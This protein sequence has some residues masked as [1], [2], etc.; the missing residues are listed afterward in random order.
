MPV[1]DTRHSTEPVSHARVCFFDRMQD[2]R[3]V[4]E[5]VWI[6]EYDYRPDIRCEVIIGE[7]WEP[8]LI[9]VAV[10]HKVDED[11]AGKIKASGYC[12]IEIDLASLLKQKE[13]SAGDL[14]QALTEPARIT[15]VNK[16]SQLMKHLKAIT[17]QE[18]TAS[19]EAC[20]LEIRQWHK[21]ISKLLLS[22]QRI[23]LPRY[24]Y[25]EE[26]LANTIKLKDGKRYP[27][28]K[29]EPPTIGGVLELHDV[30]A[31]VDSRFD[32]QL[33]YNGKRY[34]LPVVLNI[35][36][37]P[38]ENLS[39]SYLVLN[40]VSLPE[41]H[42]FFAKLRWGRSQKAEAYIES[43]R[44][45]RSNVI[46]S[47]EHRIE[48]RIRNL[49]NQYETARSNPG[50]V[51]SPN[52]NQIERYYQQYTE[53]LG[54]LSI[55]ALRY[56][57]SIEDGWIFGCPQEYWQVIALRT[58]CYVD[59]GSVGVPFLSDYLKRNYNI[60]AISLI[61]QLRVLDT[62]IRAPNGWRVLN[63]YL[64]YL[65]RCNVLSGQYKEFRKIIIYGAEYRNKAITPFSN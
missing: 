51:Q 11:K 24:T 4:E 29:S 19:V 60:A 41:P 58:I 25:S 36:Q 2:I 8:L 54:R 1:S 15:W 62:G 28:E 14:E 63:A 65:D 50:L 42:I 23:H 27:V 30:S 38:K 47:H 5:E 16:S 43:V 40:D 21:Q 48:H 55:N 20:N 32:L 18:S 56:T 46:A 12:A 9:E 64:Q 39:K 59:N 7:K 34:S 52:I 17:A 33:G 26:I 35:G 3:A 37:G 45:A 13:I 53:E 44:Q 61:H 49:V 57:T 31:L 22:N 6:S 10:T